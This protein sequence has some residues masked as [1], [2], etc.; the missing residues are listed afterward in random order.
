MRTIAAFDMPCALCVVM[1]DIGGY[2]K[3]PHQ[4]H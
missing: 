2:R 1:E 4:T 3:A